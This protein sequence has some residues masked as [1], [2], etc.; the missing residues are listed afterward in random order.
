M[1]SIRITNNVR[2]INFVSSKLKYLLNQSVITYLILI[3]IH[4]VVGRSIM[5]SGWTGLSDITPTLFLS[6][7]LVFLLNH[8]KFNIFAKMTSNLILGFFLVLWHGSIEADGENFYFR[9]IDSL[10]RFVEWISIAKDGGISTDTVP[11]A[12][13][14]MLISWLVATVV[15]MLTIKFNSAW[16]PTVALGLALMTNL[17][18]RHGQLEY[19]FALFMMGSIILFAHLNVIKKVNVWRSIKLD[20]PDRLNW[21]GVQVGI[22]LAISVTIVIFVVPVWE[23]RSER[24][25]AVWDEIRSPFRVF[26]DPAARLLAG[27]KGSY[28]N[29]LIPPSDALAFTGPIEL[30]DTP[31]MLVQSDYIAPH[32]AKIFSEY[33]SEG[34]LVGDYQFSTLKADSSSEIISSGSLESIRRTYIPLIPTK[35]IIPAGGI[36]TVSRDANIQILSPIVW[37]VPLTENFTNLDKFPEN[38]G[39]IATVLVE[40]IQEMSYVTKET[41]FKQD[42][43]LLIINTEVLIDG[44]WEAIKNKQSGPWEFQISDQNKNKMK[45]EVG[46]IRPSLFS[47]NKDDLTIGISTET[48]E[49]F[50][51]NLEIQKLSGQNQM[52]AVS[53]SEI[54][55][56]KAYTVTSYIPTVY[57]DILQGADVEFPPEIK[58]IYLQLPRDLPS[59]IKELSERII[60]K[61]NASTTFEKVEAIRS[62]LQS[63]VYSTEISGPPTSVDGVFYF[64]FLTQN[65]PC[66]SKDVS[67]DIDAIKGYSQYFASAGTV[68]LRTLGVP[69]RFVGGWSTG[70]YDDQ[71]KMII[72][73]DN[74][75]H[76][77]IQVYFKEH[78]WVDVEVTPGK[79]MS[80]GYVSNLVPENERKT[81][82]DISG[83]EEDDLYMQDIEDLSQFQLRPVNNNQGNRNL[84]GVFGFNGY[85]LWVITGVLFLCLG[86][87]I[88]VVWWALSVKNLNPEVKSFVIMS[89]LASFA[90]IGRNKQ[91]TPYEFAERL[92]F[93][94]K[95]IETYPTFVAGVYSRS[96]YG[97]R[98][99]KTEQSKSS[100]QLEFIDKQLFR[101]MIIYR[102]KT[103]FA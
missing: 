80:V 72:V 69:T 64:L 83:F 102:L 35:T 91:E 37:R 45:L 58:E 8:L 77:W 12:M 50:D 47:L 81:P 6:V 26:K 14:I 88:F 90:G 53:I 85:I 99:K 67:C 51:L 61:E 28:R 36:I 24:V 39:N 98:V 5:L 73:R 96:I 76:G 48:N 22:I 38:I 93:T 31:I 40:A 65:E 52:G 41:D 25:T 84:Y 62:F 71:S 7:T 1:N 70:T 42:Q 59:E 89:Q 13:L 29:F 87:L 20:I 75:R 11:F 33:T 17:S 82:A 30:K 56:D 101:I 55:R 92:E 54:P 2:F 68:M 79:T 66:P 49:G 57:G 44:F 95:E 27:I 100:F 94:I 23:P 10:N 97:P 9:S 34:W 18:Y 16:I 74:N 43:K 63:Q 103:L 46:Y 60:Q 86:V 19:T 32:P 4:W 15:T 3:F 78:G 21:S